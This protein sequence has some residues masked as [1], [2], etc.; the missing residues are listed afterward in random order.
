METEDQHPANQPTAADSSQQRRSNN[1]KATN[2]RRRRSKR[3]AALPEDGG[4]DSPP[5]HPPSDWDK[6]ALS[7]QDWRLLN[8]INKGLLQK[9]RDQNS[10]LISS[11]IY[12]EKELKDLVF[13][14]ASEHLRGKTGPINNM[15]EILNDLFYKY[16]G[17]FAVYTKTHVRQSDKSNTHVLLTPPSPGWPTD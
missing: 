13:K 8:S 7:D 16:H 17:R 3:I 12:N 14:Y 5:K 15:E 9:L 4:G 2:V 6:E 1:G 10:G 11:L